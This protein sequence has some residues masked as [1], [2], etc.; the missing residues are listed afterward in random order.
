MRSLLVILLSSVSWL[1]VAQEP[2]SPEERFR[3]DPVRVGLSFSFDLTDR[4]LG[5][6]NGDRIAN[7]I[8]DPGSAHSS[9]VGFSA[10]LDLMIPL[11]DRLSLMTGARYVDMGFRSRAVVDTLLVEETILEDRE[12]FQAYHFQY[13]KLPLALH[14]QLGT[15]SFRT[16]FMAGVHVGYLAGVYRVYY[17]EQP[18][19]RNPTE[20]LDGLH[21]FD[22]LN[23]FPMAEVG[24]LHRTTSRIWTHAGINGRYG[25]LPVT[26]RPVS[27]ALWSAGI[28]LGVFYSFR[29][30]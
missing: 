7:T 21:N 11:D 20:R 19:G 3:T 24:L 5:S 17:D 13:L 28:T 15:G 29:T 8:L 22:H 9:R 4:E 18:E 30:P 10:G 26:D 6:E 2:L 14:L 1:V 16:T 25:V 23:L 12:V 27:T